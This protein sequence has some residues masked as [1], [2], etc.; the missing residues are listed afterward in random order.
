M[1]R[2][3]VVLGTAILVLTMAVPVAAITRGGEL[4]GNA[5]PY[6]GLMDAYGA[7]GTYLWSCSGALISETVYVTAGHC[8][9]SPAASVKIWFDPDPISVGWLDFVGFDATGT[10][11]THPD[12]DPAAFYLFDLGVVVLDEAGFDPGSFAQLPDVGAIDDMGKGRKNNTIT[13]VGYGVNRIVQNPVKGLIKFEWDVQRRYADLMVVNTKGVAGLGPIFDDIEGTGSIAVS[14]DSKHGGTCFGDSGG[15]QLIDGNVIA[16]VTSF[17]LNG[18]C[19]GIGGAYRVDQQ[20]DLD[21][22]NDFLD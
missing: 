20:D 21:F 15:P 14:G 5:H 8:T 3:M 18:N 10:P 13:A 19:A 9:E 2:K 16:A 11:Y 1:R 4:D 17:G 7:D 6:V 22:I 12:Y